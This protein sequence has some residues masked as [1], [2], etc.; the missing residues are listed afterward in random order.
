MAKKLVMLFPGV[1]CVGVIIAL[2][3]S[4]GRWSGVDRMQ[5]GSGHSSLPKRVKGL[6]FVILTVV[7]W[8]A[9]EVGPLK[10]TM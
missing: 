9:R 1:I 10:T 5:M 3:L 7:N 4:G 6:V 2:V 8:P